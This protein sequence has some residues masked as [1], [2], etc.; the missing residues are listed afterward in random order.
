MYECSR[1]HGPGCSGNIYVDIR[2]GS[3]LYFMIGLKGRRR[4]FLYA[5]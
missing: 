3:G 5:T 1:D 4:L 2:A